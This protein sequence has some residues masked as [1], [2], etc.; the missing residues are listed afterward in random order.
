MF[1]EYITVFAFQKADF[2]VFSGGISAALQRENNNNQLMD[3]NNQMF[4]LESPHASWISLFPTQRSINS[5]HQTSIILS[6]ACN[7]LLDLRLKRE[8]Y[9]GC[10]NALRNVSLSSQKWTNYH[11]LLRNNYFQS[12]H[13]IY[14][15]KF[16]YSFKS[17]KKATSKHIARLP[18]PRADYFKTQTMFRI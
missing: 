7:E 15:I 17:K 2:L 5:K 16:S 18:T 13:K 11:Q 8:M 10:L 6:V 3:A 12:W 4:S 1:I 9:R 14:E